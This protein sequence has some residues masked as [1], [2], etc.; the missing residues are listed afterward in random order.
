LTLNF[1]LMNKNYSIILIL[2]TLFVVNAQNNK[3]VNWISENSIEIED[4]N[5]D[6]E[7]SIFKQNTPENFAKAKIYGFGE[8][9]HNTKEFF[10]LKAKFF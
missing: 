5:P 9:S 4:A 6:S 3:T 7:L 1:N 10:N 2:F 8:A